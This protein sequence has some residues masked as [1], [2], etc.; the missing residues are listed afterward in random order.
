VSWAR[1]AK[2]PNDPARERQA[3]DTYSIAAGNFPFDRPA[4]QGGL[5]CQQY[6]SGENT[7][8]AGVI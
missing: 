5:K 1:F 7:E 2:L 4:E 3:A 6:P 8:V